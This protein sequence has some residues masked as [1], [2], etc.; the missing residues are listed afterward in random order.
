MKSLHID[1][2]G[3]SESRE[4]LAADQQAAMKK[5]F[6]GLSGPQRREL[7]LAQ[8]RVTG[9]KESFAEMMERGKREANL[10]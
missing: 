7:R 10:R 4:K 9:K 8:K 5:F 6:A 3:E 2:P 1:G